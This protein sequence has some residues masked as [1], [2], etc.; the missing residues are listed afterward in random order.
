MNEPKI[1]R[2]IKQDGMTRGFSA[3]LIAVVLVFGVGVWWTSTRG[4]DA[5]AD[6]NWGLRVV[7]QQEAPG[8][9]GQQVMTLWLI[10]TPAGS[11]RMCVTANYGTGGSSNRPIWLSCEWG[12]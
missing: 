9:A 7:A 5:H 11:Q 1:P 8:R 10:Q 2:G 4:S 6:G 12:S 3:F